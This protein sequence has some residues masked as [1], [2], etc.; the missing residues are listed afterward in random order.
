VM[1][2]ESSGSGV[3]GVGVGVGAEGG[4]ETRRRQKQQQ[5]QQQ[6]PSMEYWVEAVVDSSRYFVIRCEDENNSKRV[7]HVGMGFRERDDAMNF[8]MGLSDFTRSIERERKTLQMQAA[9]AAATAGTTQSSSSPDGSNHGGDNGV[10][11]DNKLLPAMVSKLSLKEGETIR[12]NLNQKNPKSSSS[13]RQNRKGGAVGS[14]GL[15]LRKPPPPASKTQQQQQQSE[16]G[17]KE[18]KLLSHA[19]PRSPSY[20]PLVAAQSQLKKDGPLR[21]NEPQPPLTTVDAEEE[22]HDDEDDW[23]DFESG[24]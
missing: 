14:G 18:K 12:L 3:G 24:C 2:V 10:N 6:Q 21:S 19:P 15:L 4:E 9:A 22:E 11:G 20:S 7:A 8:K 1:N 13:Q 17:N 5:Q 23:G 16:N